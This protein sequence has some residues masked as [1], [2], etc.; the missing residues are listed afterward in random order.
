MRPVIS[1][2]PDPSKRYLKRIKL[3][4]GDITK[5]HTDAI[6]SVLPQSLEYGGALNEAILAA[7]GHRLDDFL[8]EHIYKPRP[9]DIY[10]VPGF[11]LPCKNIFFAIM[12]KWSSEFDRQD[13]YLL[14][15]VRKAM[16]AGLSQL[17]V[18]GFVCA[19]SGR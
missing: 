16:T 13:K 18:P 4:H 11:N 2:P 1:D 9:G 3:V 19:I 6:V 7:A 15:A 17:K 12:P 10:A 14:T 8:L 5:Q